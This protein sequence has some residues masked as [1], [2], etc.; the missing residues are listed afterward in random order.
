M[1]SPHTVGLI[2]LRPSSDEL[3]GRER[4]GRHTVREDHPSS[5]EAEI[6][7]FVGQRKLSVTADTYTH[8][9]SDGRELNYEQLLS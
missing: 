4:I 5:R 7:P 2:F 8:V 9:L 6:A 1:C 3:A